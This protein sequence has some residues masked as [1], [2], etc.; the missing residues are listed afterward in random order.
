MAY[1]GEQHGLAQR[2]LIQ[3]LGLARMAGDDALGAEILAAMSQQAVYVARPGQAV[4]LAIHQP[5]GVDLPP[6]PFGAIGHNA[7]LP[8]PSRPNSRNPA[9]RKP[10]NVRSRL[11]GCST[12][13]T[14]LYGL[15]SLKRST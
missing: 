13:G 3:A 14:A 1:D 2:Y 11:G 10:G 12:A 8:V 9:A 15:R 5:V 4:D 7:R 6:G